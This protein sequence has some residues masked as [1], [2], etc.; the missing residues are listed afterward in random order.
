MAWFTFFITTN[1]VA[2]GLVVSH[3]VKGQPRAVTLVV[4]V[5]LFFCFQ[6]A[7]AVTGTRIVQRMYSAIDARLEELV[8]ECLSPDTTPSRR[9]RVHAIVL[10]TYVRVVN[11]IE[12]TLKSM[13]VCW[14]LI[15]GATAFV[16]A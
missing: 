4:V 11:L 2:M 3:A 12:V 15:M 16:V 1:F 14:I 7:L 10:H 6:N 9:P 5:G 8:I 13:I